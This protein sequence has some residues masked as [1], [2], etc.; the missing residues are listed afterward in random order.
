MIMMKKP[1]F[2]PLMSAALLAASPLAAQGIRQSVEVTNEYETRFADFQKKGP[3]PRVPDSLYRFD[4]SFDYSVFDSPYKGAYEFTPYEIKLTP[5]PLEYDGRLLHLRAGAGY[6]LHPLLE[7]VYTPVAR[8]DRGLS[9]Y[10][11]GSGYYGSSFH[12]LHEA[13]GVS[14]HYLGGLGRLSYGASYEG[15]FAGNSDIRSSYHSAGV[16]AGLTSREGSG[17]FFSYD[18]KFG[19]RFGTD[20]VYSRPDGASAK[21]Y[22]GNVGEHNLR[23]GGSI[24]PALDERYNLLIDFD[25]NMAFRGGNI[26]S[27]SSGAAGLAALTPHMRFIVGQADLDAGA[28]LDYLSSSG[29]YTLT[30][31]LKA[32]LELEML[33]MKVFAG[34]DGGRS[35]NSYHSLKTLNHLYQRQSTPDASREK[36]NFYAGLQGSALPYLQYAL[37]GGY[38]IRSD[39]PL[40]GAHYG[41]GFADYSLAYA[42]L[43]LAW[44]SERFEAD[45][46]LNFAYSDISGDAAL[47]APAKFSADLRLSYNWLERVYAGITAEGASSRR[48]VS[49]ALED[50]PG[51]V[52]L[53]LAGEYRLN[54]RWGV[55]A[56]LG[57]LI[58]M[59]IER[60]PG[61]VEK[62]PYFTVGVSLNL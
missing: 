40:D 55:W 3:S 41:L 2:V 29:S 50:I 39:S 20:G 53:G 7:A 48:S 12:D 34:M 15:A 54:R 51:Y 42:N 35:L 18:V 4:Y 57:N 47:Y 61:C 24:G 56:H 8:T 59:R 45:G 43:R 23:I 11:S 44:L 32:S 36:I 21:E 25:F 62:G 60:H 31:V 27:G 17:S 14:G 49:S 38:A 10:N 46:T 33:P 6:T 26:S 1:G 22:A 16:S 52:D 37:K 58:G 9:V 5:S 30:P 19:Y 28:R 13:L